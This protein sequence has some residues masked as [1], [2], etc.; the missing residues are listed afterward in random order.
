MKIIKNIILT[1]LYSITAIALL[2]G[3]CVAASKADEIIELDSISIEYQMFKHK[4]IDPMITYDGLNRKIDT[5]LNLNLNTTVLSYFYWNSSIISM[6]DYDPVYDY[7]QFRTIGLQMRLGIRLTDWIDIGYYHLSRHLMDTPQPTGQSFQQMD[8][9][10]FKL[11]LYN[12]P[13]H[14]NGMW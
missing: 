8:A 5:G 2:F 11:K 9:I 10:E 12:N 7:G 14:R 4:G 3:F 1:I 6:K 13:H